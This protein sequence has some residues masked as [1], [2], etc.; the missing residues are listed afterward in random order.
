MCEVTFKNHKQKQTPLKKNIYTDAEDACR[1]LNGYALDGERI[2][3]Q[4]ARS[5]KETDHYDHYRSRRERSRSRSRDRRRSRSRD[6][7]NDKRRR[8]GRDKCYDCGS[9]GKQFLNYPYIFSSNHLY[10]EHT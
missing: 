9:T 1:G 7:D 3:V 4:V 10:I 5:R 8:S 6:H 2:I